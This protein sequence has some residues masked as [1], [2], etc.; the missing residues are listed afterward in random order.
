VVSQI[1]QPVVVTVTAF[2]PN[3]KLY[4]TP[5]V[6]ANPV[7]RAVPP[8]GILKEDVGAMF[9]MNASQRQEGWLRVETG[10]PAFSSF[11]TYGSVSPP[12]L[13][14]HI[15]Q[16]LPLTNAVFSHQANTDGFST[17][18]S[19]LNQASLA[20]NVTIA[21]LRKD[22]TV[23][24][25]IQKTLAANQRLDELVSTLLRSTADINE[26]IVWVRSEV[27]IFM[28]VSF[29]TSEAVA[30]VPADA[31]DPAFTPDAG[32]VIVK[33]SPPLS[34]IETGSS[35]R[36]A[37]R[38][39][40]AASDQVTWSVNGITGG[41]SQLGIISSS[42]VYRAP[43]IVPS[44]Q[45]IT[46]EAV[47]NADPERSSGAS[48]EILA[49]QTAGGSFALPRAVAFINSLKKLFV[50]ESLALSAKL[51]VG[52]SRA[53]ISEIL[54]TAGDRDSV[55]TLENELIEKMVPFDDQAGTS[56]LLM[57]GQRTGQIYRL[58]ISDRSLVVVA[59]GFN[60]PSSLALDAASGDLLV[61]EEGAGALRVVSRSSF[62]PSFSAKSPVGNWPAAPDAFAQLF[63]VSRPAGVIVDRC[64]GLVYVT[65][66]SKGEIVAYNR[67]TGDVQTVITGLVNP[68]EILGLYRNGL[69][70]S[71]SF[72]LFVGEEGDGSSAARILQIDPSRG[73]VNTWLVTRGVSDLAWIRESNPFLASG[74]PGMV[75]GENLI[76]LARLVFIPMVEV[77]RDST[78]LELRDQVQGRF[79]AS[80]LI[81]FR[82]HQ[83]FAN[84]I[85]LEL[86]SGER[87]FSRSSGFYSFKG[88]PPGKYRVTPKSSL[89]S[90]QPAFHDFTITAFDVGDLD[91]LADFK[92]AATSKPN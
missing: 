5:E 4:F 85:E 45:V 18:L 89:L 31:A 36:F 42:G 27:P 26:G 2:K 88:L 13:A 32:R 80:G 44:P 81:S 63:S 53:V 50:A 20:S 15:S 19:L 6:T 29:G 60:Q 72:S 86:S 46:I 61:A 66:R 41:N 3:G 76:N 37:A 10:V 75:Y 87:T 84:G 62:D 21:S 40:G 35:A 71:G 65:D 24:Q 16:L 54:S 34:P 70:C 57:A 82:T 79:T 28:S 91:F 52:P 33:I 9:G 38:L 17:R 55:L 64:S 39:N 22:G 11:V 49:R 77:Y 48:V 23:L 83:I 43:V 1:D 47:S 14:A 51:A 67:F 90:F 25:S 92:Q 58:R 69:Y 12:T 73:I 8:H 78:N 30:S 59:S 74:S 68:G 7:T 56:Y